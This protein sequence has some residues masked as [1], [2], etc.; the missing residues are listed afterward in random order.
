MPVDTREVMQDAKTIPLTVLSLEGLDANFGGGRT[1]CARGV[2]PD[3]GSLILILVIQDISLGD[4]LNNIIVPIVAVLAT[5]VGLVVTLGQLTAGGRL[6]KEAEF[7]KQEFADAE[8]AQDKA[9][10]QSLHR[11]ALGKL[12][13]RNGVPLRRITMVL[14]AL[15][16][17][18]FLLI[19][20]SQQLVLHPGVAANVLFAIGAVG[21]V[22]GTFIA[23]GE[24]SVLNFA[25]RAVL[26]SYLDGR[27]MVADFDVMPDRKRMFEVLGRRGVVEVLL[28]SA[29]TSAVMVVVTAYFAGLLNEATALPPWVNVLATTGY[30]S[31]AYFLFAIAGSENFKRSEPWTHPRPLTAIAKVPTNPVAPTKE[32]A[33]RFFSHTRK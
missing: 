8:L 6:R 2:G 25:R 12:V 27:K 26:L 10:Y 17:G 4:I 18:Q 33:S 3:V 19:F 24:Y 21:G 13:A 28:V 9:V 31:I 1:Q 7:W 20:G 32:K 22:A 5:V 30:I 23:L 16:P 11:L 14:G 29:S 15:V